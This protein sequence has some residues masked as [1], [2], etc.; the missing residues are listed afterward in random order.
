MSADCDGCEL[1]AA[2]RRAFIRDMAMAAV[3]ALAVSALH[4][5][6][7]LAERATAITPLAKGVRQR[8]YS[9]PAADAIEVDVDGEVII[10]RWQNRVYAF[11]TKCPH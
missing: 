11:S 7:A 10:A 6:E 2:G 9:I 3:G 4:P 8:T 1:A 5:V